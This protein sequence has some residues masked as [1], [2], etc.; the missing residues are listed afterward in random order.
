MTSTGIARK[1]LSEGDCWVQHQNLAV[2][3]PLVLPGNTGFFL[4]MADECSAYTIIKAVNNIS[5]N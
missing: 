5:L 3:V 1:H 2:V 4:L